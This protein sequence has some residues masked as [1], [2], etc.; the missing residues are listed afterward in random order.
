[1]AHKRS[2]RAINFTV[3]PGAKIY[4]LQ[5]N[6]DDI[7]ILSYMAHQRIGF[8]IAF[9]FCLDL[10]TTTDEDPFFPLLRA[11]TDSV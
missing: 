8:T 10:L 2:S 3:E 11:F 7:R 1:M 6:S 4:G 5:N 9:L